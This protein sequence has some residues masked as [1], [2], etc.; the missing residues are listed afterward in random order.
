MPKRKSTPPPHVEPELLR[1][2]QVT[3]LLGISPRTLLKL[4]EKEGADFPLP[5]KLG[6]RGIAWKRS[7]LL[8]WIETLQKT[9]YG[10][11]TRYPSI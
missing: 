4:R 11:K 6:L 9:R 7:E 2:R 1:P 8:A 3:A 5:V 10:A